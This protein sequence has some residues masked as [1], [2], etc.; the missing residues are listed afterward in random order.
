MSFRLLRVTM[1]ALIVGMSVVGGKRA[2][3]VLCPI[4]DSIPRVVLQHLRPART[5][6]RRTEAGRAQQPPKT[7]GQ[8]IDVSGLHQ[9][10][11]MIVI[12]HRALRSRPTADDRFST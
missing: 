1:T 11:I 2:I 6:E 9:Q 8:G 7:R 3:H 10:S 12:D 4:D 5:S